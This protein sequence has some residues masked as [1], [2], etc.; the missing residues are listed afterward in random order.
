[1]TSRL[2]AF[3]K[4][5]SQIVHWH[6]FVCASDPHLSPWNGCQHQK[7]PPW[8]Q[9]FLCLGDGQHGPHVAPGFLLLPLCG[10]CRWAPLSGGMTHVCH[11]GLSRPGNG[12]LE[13]GNQIFSLR[14]SLFLL[15]HS[16]SYWLLLTTFDLAHYLSKQPD[17]VILFEFRFKT[18]KWQAFYKSI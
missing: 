10:W 2:R 15:P 9:A 11:S 4:F 14:N 16:W 1:M 12:P 17:L 5:W 13:L 3:W 18:P 7:W 6:V 8:G